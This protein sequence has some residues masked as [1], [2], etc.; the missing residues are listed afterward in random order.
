LILRE[1]LVA[2]D[3]HSPVQEED[4]SEEIVK[5]FLALGKPRV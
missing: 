1:I 4:A 2:C 5:R 3:H